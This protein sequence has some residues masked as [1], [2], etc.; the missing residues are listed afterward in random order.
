MSENILLIV[1]SSF[2]N[3]KLKAENP[4]FQV[5]AESKLKFWAPIIIIV[6]WCICL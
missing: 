1:K 5:N 4:K 3:A 6:W 2:K